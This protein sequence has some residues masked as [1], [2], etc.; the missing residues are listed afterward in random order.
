MEHK[1]FHY[2][3][4]NEIQEE[5]GKIGINLPLSDNCSKLHQI[6]KMGNKTVCNRLVI[7]PMEGCDGMADGTPGELTRR[8]YQRFAASGAGM[9][10][11]E[12]VAVTYDGRSNPRQ[13]YIHKNNVDAF[14]EVVS[15]IKKSCFERYGFEPILIMQATHSGRHSKPDGVPKPVIAQ[16]KPIFEKNQPLPDSCIISDGELER[17]EEVYGVAAKLAEQAGFDGIDVKNCHGYLNNELMT[18]YERPGNYG[19]S[20]ENRTRFF[21]RSI[22][23]CKAATKGDFLVTSRMNVYDGYP[24]PYGFGTKDQNASVDLQEPLAVIELLVKKYGFQMLDVTIGNP[25]FNPHVNRP[26]DVGGYI[27]PEHPLEGIA[28]M[29]RCV[30]EVQRQFPEL[31]VIGSAFSYLRQFSQY[32]AAGAIE[33]GAC[34]LAGFG[35]MAFAYPEFARDILQGTLN[36]RKVCVACGKCSELM[37]GGLQAG[38][39]VRDSDVY[40]PL[41]QK[42]KQG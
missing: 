3:S 10:W 29:M 17:L 2:K 34:S 19:G 36:P 12:A 37:R 39:V 8:R 25:Y 1:K 11:F 33:A 27:P 26:Y 24:F 41:Y 42:I 7:Q 4:I 5:C 6:L 38:C 22:E 32:L 30:G 14:A 21:Y 18:A 35:R 15:G 40:L 28:R 13:L 20:L 9:I 31:A 16:H 23:A